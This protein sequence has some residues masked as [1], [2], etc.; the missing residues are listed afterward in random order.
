MKIG[1]LLFGISFFNFV[2]LTF[3]N[4][5]LY[6]ELLFEYDANNRLSNQEHLKLERKSEHTS[7]YQ[8]L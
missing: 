4:Y 7:Y 5:L 8:H 3:G 1:I 2:G 6:T